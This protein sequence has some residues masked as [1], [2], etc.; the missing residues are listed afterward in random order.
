MLDNLRDVNV[1]KTID[2]F[3]PKEECFLFDHEGLPLYQDDNHL[4]VA[5]SI[6]QAEQALKPYLLKRKNMTLEGKQ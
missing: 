1:I 3:C 5:G 6:F 4:S 2:T